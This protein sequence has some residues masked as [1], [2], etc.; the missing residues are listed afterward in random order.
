MTDLNVLASFERA[1]AVVLEFLREDAPVV[2][3]TR[4]VVEARVMRLVARGHFTMA[5]AARSL[6]LSRSTILRRCR[7]LGIDPQA[8]RADY[9]KRIK[10]HIQREQARREKAASATVLRA[11]Q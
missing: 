6:D 2:E 5:D 1:E 11:N 4:D 9:L 7:V 10:A 3:V 8:A